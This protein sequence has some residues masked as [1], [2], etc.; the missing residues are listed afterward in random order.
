MSSIHLWGNPMLSR[1]VINLHNPC[2]HTGIGDALR[3]GRSND[4]AGIEIPFVSGLACCHPLRFRTGWRGSGSGSGR[5]TT[6]L[7]TGPKHALRS[8][9]ATR[10]QE[11]L[12]QRSYEGPVQEG[13]PGQCVTIRRAGS[14]SY[15]SFQ[16]RLKFPS[17]EVASVCFLLYGQN[18]KVLFRV[19]EK[20]RMAGL[21]KT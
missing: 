15:T 17:R 20:L 7:K 1:T 9:P 4:Y 18:N 5:Q 16:S 13:C 19:G 14:I 12:S 8:V 3:N 10:W 11:K 2:G 6:F 21:Q